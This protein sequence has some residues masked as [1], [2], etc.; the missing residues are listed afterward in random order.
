MSNI[1]TWMTI[2][3][4]W[5]QIIGIIQWATLMT[6]L[7]GHAR[8]THTV[9]KRVYGRSPLYMN[10]SVQA[11]A[12]ACEL[13]GESAGGA[14]RPS[15]NSFDSFQITNGTYRSENEYI[16]GES[17]LYTGTSNFLANA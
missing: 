11:N 17:L 14:P 5:R 16:L 6:D 4:K 7:L 12:K 2:N 10:L 9:Y 8:N 13:Q 1:V 3:L 15:S